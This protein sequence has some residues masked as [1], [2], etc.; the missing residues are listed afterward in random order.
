MKYGTLTRPENS[1]CPAILSGLHSGANEN[2]SE[3]CIP[4]SGRMS[5]PLFIKRRLLCA[6]REWRQGDPS[7]AADHGPRISTTR[8][9]LGKT[10]TRANRPYTGQA[11]A[12]RAL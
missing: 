12:W 10:R 11:Y 1:A 3:E 6:V 9:R 7:I 5:V 2:T 4:E 8:P